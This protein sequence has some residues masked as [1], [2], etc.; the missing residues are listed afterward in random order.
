MWPQFLRESWE[1]CSP[2]GMFNID[3]ARPCAFEREAFSQ[4]RPR[5][6]SPSGASRT[7]SLRHYGVWFTRRADGQPRRIEALLSSFQLCKTGVVIAKQFG[8]N[9][10]PGSE[11]VFTMV[12]KIITCS[13]FPLWNSLAITV[14]VGVAVRNKLL[15]Q[16][17]SW[18]WHGINYILQAARKDR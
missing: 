7:P 3:V 1:I 9:T 17:Q 11:E 4:G 13:F 12:A 14:T 6:L 5:A 15:I 18:W 2:P 8:A 16:L 10:K